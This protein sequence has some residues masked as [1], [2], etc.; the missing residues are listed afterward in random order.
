M[1]SPT[2]QQLFG[3]NPWVTDPPPGGSSNSGPY[4]YSPYY[5]ATVATA[6]LLCQIIELGAGL[7]PGSCKVVEVNAITG[8]GGPLG[9]NQPNQMIQLPDESITP[10]NAGLMAKYFNDFA[11]VE[12]IN[13]AFAMEIGQP[14][15][16][17]MPPPPAAPVLK[18]TPGVE[19]MI[20]AIGGTAMQADGT[21]WKRLS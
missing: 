7:P 20:A 8:V 17:V 10:R 12:Q 16:F 6:Q 3:P 18:P 1:T 21:T 9:Q 2:A 5:F 15:S 14:F 4:L 19:L 11:S 13:Q